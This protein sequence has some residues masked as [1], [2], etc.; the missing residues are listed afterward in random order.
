M[1]E[2]SARLRTHQLNIERYQRLLKTELTDLESRFLEK[3]LSEERFCLAM[4]TRGIDL[5]TTFK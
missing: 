5:P 3:R 2:E 4:L 1:N